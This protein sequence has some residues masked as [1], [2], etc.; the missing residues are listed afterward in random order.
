[1][2]A[3]FLII[4]L[5][6]GV[7]GYAILISVSSVPV[8]IF[9]TSLVASGM[10]PGVILLMTWIAINSGGFTKRAAS[11]SMP[12]VVGQC[13][14]IMGTHIYDNPPRFVKGHSVILG[15]LVVGIISTSYIW[16]WMRRQNM[17][18]DQTAQEYADRAEV[19]PDAS[20]SLE[21]ICDFH[22]NFRYII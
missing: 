2:K 7:I 14:S 6:L 22:P 17:L 16:W 20:K 9:A 13:F 3:P 4:C 15:I 12:E 18:K 5:F 11:W 21:D 8:K 10:Y 1:M 19:N